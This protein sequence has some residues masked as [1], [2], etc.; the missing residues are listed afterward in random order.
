ML[1]EAGFTAS[2]EAAVQPWNVQIAGP[3]DAEAQARA[4]EAT[5]RAWAGVRW[6]RGF[7][8]WFV[9]S[10]RQRVGSKLA[11][12]HIPRASAIAV[13]ARHYRH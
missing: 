10:E 12:W 13:L 3:V 5:F 8:W 11:H 6:F 1:G 4:Y 9:P 2:A 7:H